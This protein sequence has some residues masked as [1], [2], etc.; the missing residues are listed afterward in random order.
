MNLRSAE[1]KPLRIVGVAV[2]I[3]L[4]AGAAAAVL[5]GRDDDRPDSPTAADNNRP[6]TEPTPALP[7][8]GTAQPSPPEPG[9]PEPP[10]A[11]ADGPGA[12]LVAPKPGDYTYRVNASDGERVSRLDAR[13]AIARGAN[14]AERR[15]VRTLGGASTTSVEIWSTSAMTEIEETDST[16]RRCVWSSPLLQMQA[17]MA[18]EATWSGRATCDFGGERRERTQRSRV[19]GSETGTFGG[20]PLA[21]VV[22]ER[23]T[24]TTFA[25][26]TEVVSTID[27]FAPE[28]GLSRTT[29]S[30]ITTTRR[31]QSGAE[32][33]K[34]RR[35]VAELLP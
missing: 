13:V 35:L 15:I 4:V 2:A 6:G 3:L 10:P 27:K 30:E 22:I 8:E 33:T 31:D 18:A 28:L 11:K 1:G 12:V 20:K 7:G 24:T 5:S 21:L 25:G 26:T 23:E 29:A 14:D 16:G 19:T 9:A 32:T 34:V 17:P